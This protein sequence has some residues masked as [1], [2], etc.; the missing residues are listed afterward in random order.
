MFAG[1]RARTHGLPK[2]KIIII[3]LYEIYAL[4]L[5]NAYSGVV[6]CKYPMAYKGININL[7]HR[8]GGGGGGGEVIGSNL[9]LSKFSVIQVGSCCI[10]HFPSFSGL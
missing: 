3:I 4:E 2:K 10:I 9:Y 5:Q 1:Y 7:I 8:G 6:S